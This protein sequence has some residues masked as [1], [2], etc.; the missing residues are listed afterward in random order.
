MGGGVDGFPGTPCGEYPG[1]PGTLLGAAGVAGFEDVDEIA[2]IDRYGI[3]EDVGLTVHTS[4]VSPCGNRV[5]LLLRK[6]TSQRQR[7]CRS[8]GR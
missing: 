8:C 4:V 1:F 3:R 7:G 2:A 5:R 6:L